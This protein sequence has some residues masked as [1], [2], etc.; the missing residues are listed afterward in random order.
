MWKNS[1]PPCVTP[2]G[3]FQSVLVSNVVNVNDNNINSVADPILDLDAANKEYVDEA[4]VANKAFP[5]GQNGD[6]QFNDNGLFGGSNNFTWGTDGLYIDGNIAAN[7]NVS[8]STITS[9]SITTTNLTTNNM[10]VNGVINSNNGKAIFEDTSSQSIASLAVEAVIFSTSV[11]NTFGTNLN[12]NS[13][14]NTFTN[15]SG[16]TMYVLVTYTVQFSSVTTGGTLMS[17]I[18]LGDDEYGKNIGVTN[19]NSDIAFNG[20]A[21]LSLEDGYG[22]QVVVNNNTEGTVYVSADSAS[23]L[24]IY[25]LA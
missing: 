15:S 18:Q 25:Q 11:L 4:I 7:G 21:M 14:N 23:V 3:N 8:A 9:S 10:T 1:T 16:S 20:S 6:I 13:S 22:I 17:Y 5:G 19:A 24:T 2:T 12:I